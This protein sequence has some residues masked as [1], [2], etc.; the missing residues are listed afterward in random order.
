LIK[1]RAY[2]KKITGPLKLTSRPSIVGDQLFRKLK[3]YRIVLGIV[4]R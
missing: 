2:Q 4:E 3:P 1:T